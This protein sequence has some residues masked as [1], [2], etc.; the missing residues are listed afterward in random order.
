MEDDDTPLAGFM[1]D[2]EA[3]QIVSVA[4]TKLVTSLDCWCPSCRGDL[5]DMD[6]ETRDQVR[7]RTM[8]MI[9]LLDEQMDAIDLDARLPP[10][11]PMH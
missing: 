8:E 5:P 3:A 6:A 11:A 7:E 1:F 2:P 9:E 4:L 10:D